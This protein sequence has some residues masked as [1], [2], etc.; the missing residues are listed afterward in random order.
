MTMTVV[1]DDLKESTALLDAGP[2]ALREALR[3]DSYLFFRQL[4]PVDDVASVA[5]D[6]L[7]VLT[8]HGWIDDPDRLRPIEPLCRFGEPEY[9]ACFSDIQSIEG[10]HRLA[11]HERLLAVA[12]AV[13]GVPEVVVHP[14]KVFHVAFPK[15]IDPDGQT[16]V[17][18]D[19]PYVQGGVD[20]LTVWVPFTQA[21]RERGSLEILEGSARRGIQPY[22]ITRDHYGCAPSLGR[23]A[24]YDTWR[25]ADFEVG[26]VVMFHSLTVHASRPN[27]TDI[28]RCSLDFRCRP[29]SEPLGVIETWPQF[30]PDVGDWKYLTR[31]WSTERWISLPAGTR[32]TGLNL[33]PAGVHVPASDLL[34][35]LASAT[36]SDADPLVP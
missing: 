26:D 32:I 1:T 2:E 36:S 28:V 9:A 33:H 20:A 21:H 15:R 4:L 3:R 30:F 11:H 22:D 16:R 10:V 19:W 35:T 18:Q 6:V 23:R 12:G 5:R 24:E 31:D 8:E 27:L 17:H 25:S 29:P 13:F 34:G 14:R 7:A